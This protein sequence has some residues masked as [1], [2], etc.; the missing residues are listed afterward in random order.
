MI[1]PTTI[2]CSAVGLLVVV[3]GLL[4]VSKHKMKSVKEFQDLAQ[5]MAN[6][7]SQELLDIVGDP[8]SWLPITLEAAKGELRKRNIDPSRIVKPVVQTS[9]TARPSDQ[10][11][12]PIPVTETI[13]DEQFPARPTRAVYDKNA[14]ELP[15][16]RII[17]AVVLDKSIPTSIKSLLI[18][19]GINFTTSLGY[20][21]ETHEQ[22][23]SMQAPPGTFTVFLYGG[24]VIGLIMIGFGILGQITKSALVGYLNGIALITVGIWNVIFQDSLDAAVKPY[25]Y[26][27]NVWKIG[28]F[29]V[30][31]IVGILQ[32]L[33]GI[34]QIYRFLRFGFY[35]I[36]LKQ[37]VRTDALIKLQ[38]I[39][40]QSPKP[41]VG[42]FKLK[43]LQSNRLLDSLFDS[44]VVGHFIK[45]G[46]YTVWLL[47]DKAF[48]IEDGLEDYFVYYR[49]SLVGKKFEGL[50]VDHV[51]NERINIPNRVLT[52][53]IS[54]NHKALE[55]FNEWLKIEKM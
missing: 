1:S 47:P 40:V 23:I 11:Q 35:P 24:L 4:A 43:L 13:K 37:A 32:C 38:D 12:Q 41:S 2:L 3:G 51:G 53:K 9:E 45:F 14:K 30:W 36:G 55:A 26:V 22:F 48:C 42:R 15:E 19:G 10:T 6:K 21:Q 44:L 50:A 29:P 18:W 49:Q 16:K 28:V 52:S 27:V 17:R 33:W 31:Q 20:Y 46:T 34:A 54:L 8:T 7:T 39:I 5:Q 25:G